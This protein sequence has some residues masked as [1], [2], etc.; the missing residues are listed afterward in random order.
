MNNFRSVSNLYSIHPAYKTYHQL[1]IVRIAPLCKNAQKFYSSDF[2]FPLQLIPS[3]TPLHNTSLKN[4]FTELYGSDSHK[5]TIWLIQT[6]I[7]M[8]YL[9]IKV[10]K[11]KKKVNQSF[12]IWQS[13]T[14]NSFLNIL[15]LALPLSTIC[16]S[17]YFVTSKQA[18]FHENLS[19]LCYQTSKCLHDLCIYQYIQSYIG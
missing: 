12:N 15:L 3:I 10:L 4:Y 9:I 1:K 17:V 2:C 14:P 11:K 13:I 8:F 7:T 19:T 16:S 5:Y 18:M 6:L